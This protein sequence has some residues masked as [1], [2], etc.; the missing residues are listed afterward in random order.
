MSKPLIKA[1]LGLMFGI[2]LALISVSAHAEGL[3]IVGNQIT[4]KK[5]TITLTKPQLQQAKARKAIAL[6]PAQSALF[7]KQVTY[8]RK[9]W[10]H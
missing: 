5:L 2:A 8:S 3:P 1:F 9:R 4:C 10:S 6:T 7:L